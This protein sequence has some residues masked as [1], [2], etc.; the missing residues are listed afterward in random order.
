MI[1]KTLIVDDHQIFL[2]G[3]RLMIEK[4]SDIVLVGEATRGK[5][6]LDVIKKQSVDLVILDIHLPDM[7]GV[8][9]AKEIKTIKPDVKILILSMSGDYKFIKTLV[10]IG[11]SGYILKENGYEELISAIRSVSQGND[12]FGEEIKN[13]LITGHKFDAIR[14][15]NETP[16]TERETQVLKQLATGQTTEEVAEALFIAVSTLETHKRNLMSKVHIKT[17]AGLVAYAYKNGYA[18]IVST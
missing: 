9:V 8:A 14:R 2:D 3:I 6:A 16:L 12:Y 7:D 1:I 15:K 10:S 5:K 4:E 18:D 11:C 13:T 17:S